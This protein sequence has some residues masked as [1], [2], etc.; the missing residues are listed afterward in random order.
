[1]G[2]WR[3]IVLDVI[4]QKM[5]W[6]C[7]PMMRRCLSPLKH[8]MAI[9]HT[10]LS[11]QEVL[12]KG[13]ALTRLVSGGTENLA[14]EFEAAFRDESWA[15][16]FVDNAP[17]RCADD[18]LAMAVEVHLHSTAAYHRRFSVCLLKSPSYLCSFAIA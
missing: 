13:T 12:S 3:R 2:R 6:E 8:M 7:I 11:E 17:M 18:A 14:R 15:N 1:M 9:T 5:F 10:K 16:A 4:E